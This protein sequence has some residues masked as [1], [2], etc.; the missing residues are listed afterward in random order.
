MVTGPA[1]TPVR[2]KDPSLPLVV[3]S[4][5]TAI[6]ASGRGNPSGVVTEPAR[7]KVGTVVV[8]VVVVGGAVVVVVGGS[9]VVVAV[10]EETVAGVA[11][12]CAT[13]LVHA[14]AASAR[15]HKVANL[16][17]RGVMVPGVRRLRRLSG[18]LSGSSASDPNSR[19]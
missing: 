9:V 5:A 4:P 1:G 16:A 3:C 13:L 6:T 10:V 2:V 7:S 11:G 15:A 19:G 12:S 17:I 14:A 8:V 18:V